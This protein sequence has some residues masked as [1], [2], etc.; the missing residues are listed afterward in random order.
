MVTGFGRVNGRVV[1][2]TAQDFTSAGGSL[3]EMHAQKICKVLDMAQDARKPFVALNDSGG[4]RIQEGIT[5]LN[6]YSSIF[7]RNGISSGDIPQISVI[8]GP[9]AGGPSI[10]RP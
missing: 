10:R 3:G 6:G 8:M 2:A 4:A 7:Y 1:F 9:T 5:S